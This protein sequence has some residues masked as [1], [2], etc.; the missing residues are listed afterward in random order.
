MPKKEEAQRRRSPEE[1]KPTI[2]SRRKSPH[3]RD[4]E[5]WL[6]KRIQEE[7]SED[8]PS[9]HNLFSDLTELQDFFFFLLS[10]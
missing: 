9:F 10:R 8:K 5:K 7:K 2:G 6:E 1:R 4:R 3:K